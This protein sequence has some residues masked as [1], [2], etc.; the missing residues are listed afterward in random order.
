MAIMEFNR[1]LVLATASEAR[2]KLVAD[3]GLSFTAAVVEIDEAPLPGEEVGAYVD[4]LARAK[5]E[6]VV[7]PSLDAVVAAVDTAIGLHGEIIGKPADE[8]HARQILKVL[9]G[10]TH[11]VASAIALRDVQD[12]RVVAELTRTRVK[13][14]SLDEGAIDWYIGTGEWK[15]RAGAYAIQGKGASLIESVDGCFTNV[16]G[17]SMPAFFRMLAELR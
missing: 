7:P 1:P 17:I 10:N 14:R 8:G 16:I 5:A 13:F 9:S 12:A 2:R 6:A 4:R 3:A 11:E 15:G